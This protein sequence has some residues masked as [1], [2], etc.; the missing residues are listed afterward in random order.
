MKLARATA[1]DLPEIVSLM[2]RAY[3]GREGWAVEEGYIQGDRIRLPDL[4]AEIA[5]KPD[6]QWLVWREEGALL[7]TVSLEPMAG[8]V[9]YLGSLTIEPSQQASQAGR[10]LLVA[11]EAIAREAGARH[12]ELTVIWVR[13][14]LIAWYQRRGYVLTG[15]TTPFPYGDER[16]GTP[17]RDDL[18]FVWLEKV[19]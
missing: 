18:Y 11:A 6:L 13:E 1:A 3:R 9:W 4:E 12:I 7:G 17:M 15:K 19:L 5:A 8:D 14:T 16:W 10:R 2:N